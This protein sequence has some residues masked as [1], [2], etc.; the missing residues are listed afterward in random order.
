M[1][2]NASLRRLYVDHTLSNAQ[3]V[4]LSQDQ[5]HY[6]FNVMRMAVGDAVVLFNGSDGEWQATIAEAGKKGGVLICDAQTRPQTAPSDLWLMCAPIRKERMAFVVEKAVELGVSKIMPVQTEYT[7]GA[8]RMRTDKL[9]ATAIEAAE[10]CEG[11]SVPDVLE[12]QKLKTALS[13]WDTNRKILHCD[14][15]LAGSDAQTGL[16]KFARPAGPWAVLIGPEG[17]FSP[18]E[19]E[20][21][22][23]N[24]QDT[25]VP[26]SLGPRI[27]RAETAAV[28][29][30]TLWQ[31][32][33]GDWA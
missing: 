3:R 29:A 7:Q 8:N 25:I 18:A 9:Q 26:I 24:L 10:Q 20:L 32:T 13:N 11:L 22:G 4:P 19:K 1:V 12:L 28:A 33:L 2:R 23:S 5:A 14:E 17:G 16:S 21:L 30:L 6:L 15:P 27:L 31:S